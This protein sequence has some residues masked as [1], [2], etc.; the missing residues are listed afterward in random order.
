MRPGA[1]EAHV[2][3]AVFVV[4]L[5]LLMAGPAAGPALAS[6]A[7]NA[8]MRNPVYTGTNASLAAA[9]HARYRHYRR[10]FARTTGGSTGQTY[11]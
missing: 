6:W 10:H 11:H 8:Q 9:Q 7:E 4:G 3:A 2:K 1:K 5:S